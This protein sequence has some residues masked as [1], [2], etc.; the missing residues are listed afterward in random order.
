[1]SPTAKF[2]TTIAYLLFCG[3]LTVLIARESV[4]PKYTS[5]KIDA[6]PHVRQKP[7]FCGEACAAMYL[8][9]LG[10]EVDQDFVYDQ[11]K[12]NPGLGRGCYTKEL[13][14][15][16]QRIGFEVGTVWYHVPA[17]AES[18]ALDDQ[19]T[20]LH[21]DLQRG[22]ASIICMRF[23]EGPAAS[24]HFRLI[25]GYDAKTDEVLFH[26]PAENDGAYRRM[27]RKQLLSLWPLKYATD[28][29]T[30][31]R[32]RLKLAKKPPVPKPDSIT[33][34]DYCQH[35]IALKAKLPDDKFHIVIQR[36]FVV[37]GDEAEST[38]QQRATRTVKWAVDHLKQDYFEKDPRDILDIWLFKD[39][40]SYYSNVKA[41]FKERP[42]T[43][44]GYYSPKHKALIMNISTGGG[45]LVHEI[46]HP[47]MAANF[48]G[49]PSWFNEGLASLYE[50][51]GEEQGH[52]RGETNWRLQGLQTAID[53]Q[54]LS[55]FEELCGTTAEAFYAD[56]KGT[57]YGQARYL[58]Y[59]LQEKRLLRKYYQEFRKSAVT[60]PTGYKTL[61]KVLGEDNMLDFQKRWEEFVL[62]LNF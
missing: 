57:H 23:A 8:R 41:V 56:N 54:R 32:F 15:A 22:Q 35:I 4:H 31:I 21:Q 14:T 42:T 51:C 53:K 10:V 16:L 43:P 37:V 5:V 40:D 45:T 19:F 58:C 60:D 25:V 48:P 20:A 62:K 1:M 27:T 34:A 17:K 24:E 36:P 12:L 33:D 52:I 30:L 29:W 18:K 59:Y 55:T 61:Q 11:S 3:S 38:V 7:D 44:F 13:A 6:I 26:E 39:E 2:Q 47:F 28:E 50:Q 49:C 9:K 46:V